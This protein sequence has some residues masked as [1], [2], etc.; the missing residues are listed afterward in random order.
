MVALFVQGTIIE[1]CHVSKNK[2]LLRQES[3]KFRQLLLH[4]YAIESWARSEG[5]S[6]GPL[7][8]CTS[9]D[10]LTIL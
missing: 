7:R 2:N 6:R 10:D 1:S 5:L 8:I 4:S 3:G 9:D